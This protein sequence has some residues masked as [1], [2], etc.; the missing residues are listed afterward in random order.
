MSHDKMMRRKITNTGLVIFAVLFSALSARAVETVRLA[1]GEDSYDLSGKMAIFEDAGGRLSVE[2]VASERFHDKWEALPGQPGDLG[3]TTSAF[4]FRFR[5]DGGEAA[6]SVRGWVLA[7]K[8]MALRTVKLYWREAGDWRHADGGY[9]E[10]GVTPEP[11]RLRLPSLSEGPRTFYLRVACETRVFLKLRLETSRVAAKRAAWRL[12][13]Y[14]SFNGLMC[15]II[16]LNLALFVV[17]KDR[18]YLWCVG[19]QLSMTIYAFGQNG[20]CDHCF[21]APPLVSWV[22]FHAVLIAAVAAFS[23]GFTR[24][25]LKTKQ[26]TPRM[27]KFFILYMASCLVLLGLAPFARWNTLMWYTVVLGLLAP[28]TAVIPGIQGIRRGF[29]PARLY[30]A[31]W[32][33]FGLFTFLFAGPF[34]WEWMESYAFQIGGAVNAVLLTW[35]M[36]ERLRILRLEQKASA[37]ALVDSERKF[38]TLANATHANIVVIQGE[39]FVYANKGFLEMVGMDLETLKRKSLEEVLPAEGLEK[40]LL[41]IE[42]ATR[43]GKRHFRY[44]VKDSKR[45]RWYEV[46]AGMVQIDGIP[47]V[48]STSLDITDRKQSDEQMFK[49]E[50][51]AAL[52]QIIAGVAHEINN[53]NNFIYFNLPILKKYM[54]HMKPMLDTHFEKDPDLKILNMPY[55]FF[56]EDI[57]KLLDNMTHGSKRITDI[58][59]DLKNYVRSSGEE[60]KKPE[61]VDGVIGQVMTLVG[62]QVRKSVKHLDSEVSAPLPMVRMN[63]GKIEQVLINLV[64]N[65]GQ[66]A[67]KDDSRVRLAARWDEAADMVEIVVEDNG[68]G[69]PEEI[70]DKIFEPFFTTKENDSG[71]GLGLAI[72]YQ[73]IEDHGGTIDVWSEPGEGTRFTVRLPAHQA[74]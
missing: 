19:F 49:A 24:S 23:T 4:W 16:L 50:K 60:D 5:V 41:G 61:S 20:L 74:G 2:D 58:V 27:D 18:S 65:A 6:P 39:A 33:S 10:T 51:M 46:S 35:A 29:K 37:A 28:V 30:L 67:D 45:G 1:A 22:R 17:L 12:F 59:S 63:V 72:S 7:L 8:T 31:A 70:K 3:Q 68:S 11:I 38:R 25:F 71:T 54:E 34:A 32:G 73:I 52:G 53:P 48:I 42:E 47:S 36:V 26:H 66:A 9:D 64:I 44:E 62:K 13:L 14:G 57:Y 15:L 21:P 40:A 55:E 43:R 69:I 56:I